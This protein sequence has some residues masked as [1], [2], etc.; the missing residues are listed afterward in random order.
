[1]PVSI[2]RVFF[3]NVADKNLLFVIPTLEVPAC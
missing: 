2:V 3:A 1:M